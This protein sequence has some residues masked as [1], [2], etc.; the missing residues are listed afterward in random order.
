MTST[1]RTATKALPTTQ[2]A[3]YDVTSFK[4][5]SFATIESATTPT[6]YGAQARFAITTEVHPSAD[7]VKRAQKASESQGEL[8][9]VEAQGLLIGL[10]ISNLNAKGETTTT[11]NL[12]YTALKFLAVWLAENAAT[13]TILRTATSALLKLDS[14]VSAPVAKGPATT[15]V[16]ATNGK[17]MSEEEWALIKTKLDAIDDIAEEFIS[18]PKRRRRVVD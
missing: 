6:F 18:E 16:A 15:V 7:S 14:Q 10:N 11:I 1:Y 3:G 4:G 8:D 9:A 5:R 13:D 17:W 12:P 2:I